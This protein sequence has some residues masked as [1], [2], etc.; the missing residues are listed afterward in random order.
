LE[1]IPKNNRKKLSIII[2]SKG[3]DLKRKLIL[4]DVL[5][6][7]CSLNRMAILSGPSFANLVADRKPT[8]ITVA[9]KNLKLSTE[10]RNLLSNKNFRVYSN[11]D[12]VGVQI[13]GAIKNIL[14]IAAGI[15]EG[16]GYGQNARA[17]VICRGLNEIE[18]ISIAFGGKKL[19]TLGLSGIGDILLTCTSLSSRNFAFGFLIG[20][21]K[22]KSDILKNKNTVTEGIENAKALYLIK[23]KYKLDTPILDAVYKVLVKKNSVKKI[24]DCLLSRPL[25]EE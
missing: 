2:C 5:K 8:A 23:R 20:K 7:L 18:R 3:F 4:S 16:L 9:S 21:G 6:P 11:K 24:A 10:V 25:K 15:T 12:I 1:G 22:N 13:N 19:T 17:A 14:A